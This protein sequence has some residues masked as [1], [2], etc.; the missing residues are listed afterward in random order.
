MAFGPSTKDRS[1]GILHNGHVGILRLSR[2]VETLR[3]IA[4]IPGLSEHPADET[5]HLHLAAPRLQLSI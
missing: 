4:R 3:C 2:L 1:I 5:R